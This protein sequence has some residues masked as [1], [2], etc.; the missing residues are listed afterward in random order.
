MGSF[1]SPAN[2]G[3]LIDQSKINLGVYNL[4]FQ[5]SSVQGCIQ[6]TSSP[7]MAVIILHSSTLLTVSYLGHHG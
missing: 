6:S 1:S 2:F 4:E 5:V 3:I 7:I